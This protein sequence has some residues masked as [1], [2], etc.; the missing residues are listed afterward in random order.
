MKIGSNGRRRTGP[1]GQKAETTLKNM[2][3]EDQRVKREAAAERKAAD[4]DRKLNDVVD[5][6][7]SE[8]LKERKSGKHRKEDDSLFPLEV[9]VNWIAPTDGTIETIVDDGS[10]AFNEEIMVFLPKKLSGVDETCRSSGNI[11]VLM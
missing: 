3:K 4:E 9:D 10:Q 2:T 1:A 7:V 6:R 5:R 8:I 11:R